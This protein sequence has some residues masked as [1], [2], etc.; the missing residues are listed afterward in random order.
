MSQ[1]TIPQD[2]CV[3]R[4]TAHASRAARGVH[5]HSLDLFG[6]LREHVHIAQKTVR[7]T[8]ADKL[9]DACSAVL[10]GA[11]GRVEINGRRRPDPAL[12]AAF[13]R[14]AGA[15]QSVVP[16]TRDSCTAETG[17]QIEAAIEA[18]DRRHSPGDHHADPRQWQVLDVDMRGLPCGKKAAL[19]TP[20]YCAK[21]RNRR[22][23][24]GGRVLATHYHAVVAD[25]LFDGKTQLI[26]A[27]LPL[28]LAAEQTL[29]WDAAQREHT[30]V[31]IDAA[32]GR[33]SDSNG[34]LFRGYPVLT[35]DSSTKR[36]THLAEHVTDWISDPHDAAR[37]IGRVP[38][39]ADADHAGPYQRSITRV[40]GG[41]L[42][43]GQRALGSGR[44]HLHPPAG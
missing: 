15:E 8:P 40:R 25:R 30:L 27:L 31:R 6:P 17:T 34:L 42:P 44:R 18:I 36:A 14:I 7:Y 20:G 29:E 11:H 35:K 5:L 19:A 37:Q 23:R 1:P 10:A 38:V 24:Q 12:Q 33:V 43:T 3:Q 2:G 32:A 28:V 39:P 13:G 26:T 4:S 9:Y 41:P 21:Q 22:G 16:D